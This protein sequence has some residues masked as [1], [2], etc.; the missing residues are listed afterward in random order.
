MLAWPLW[1]TGTAHLSLSQCRRR[2]VFL[3]GTFL[4]FLQRS[5][6]GCIPWGSAALTFTTGNMVEL[7]ILLWRIPWCW[8]MK[9]LGLWSRWDQGWLT[10]SQVIGIKTVFL[11]VFLQISSGE[12][13]DNRL[14]FSVTFIYLIFWAVN[15]TVWP[16]PSKEC[17]CAA[18]NHAVWPL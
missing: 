15:C 7:G 18:I 12:C 5:C 13:V 4:P 16:S 10:S 9:L 3:Q 6:C 14:C 1:G 2:E 11:F 8:G 17:H